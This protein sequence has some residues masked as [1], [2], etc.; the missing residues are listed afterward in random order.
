MVPRRGAASRRRTSTTSAIGRDPSANLGAKV[1]RTLRTAPSPRYAEGAA[2]ERRP[3]ARRDGELRGRRRPEVRRAEVHNV[4]HHQAHVASAFFVSPFEEAAVLSIDGFGDFA[5]HDAGA[6]AT[7]RASRC[8][9]ACSSRTRSGSSTPR[10]PSGSASRSYGDEGKVMGLAP[11]G[12]AALPRRRCA[13]L[14]RLDG[15]R[16]FELDLDYFTHHRRA[17]T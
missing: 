10:S 11:Y 1:L 4:E 7:A 2:R 5:S 13:Q 17:S 14:V 16:C 3:G 9:T 12:D 6:R 8:S 15:R